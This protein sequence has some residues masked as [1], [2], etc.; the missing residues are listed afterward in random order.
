MQTTKVL[1]DGD[2]VLVART[3][4]ADS[5]GKR[6]RLTHVLEEA[7]D[8]GLVHTPHE[9][10]FHSALI[11]FRNELV[12]EQLVELTEDSGL[13]KENIILVGK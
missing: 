13:A 7:Q 1:E 4:F 9:K 12:K 2:A 8:L 10:T 3:R 11:M 5:H 6:L